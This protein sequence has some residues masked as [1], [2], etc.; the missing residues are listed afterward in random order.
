MGRS[1]HR[2][3]CPWFVHRRVH[4]TKPP[5]IA[6]TYWVGGV[7][8]VRGGRAGRRPGS[9]AAISAGFV[10]L[11]AGRRRMRPAGVRGGANP[12]GPLGC[13]RRA[14]GGSV[15]EGGARHRPS[16]RRRTPRHL[17]R[18]LRWGGTSFWDFCTP[19]AFRRVAWCT[20]SGLL[21]GQGS[22]LSRETPTTAA[23]NA[24]SIP[25]SCEGIP[26]FRRSEAFVILRIRER[27][28][29][30]PE[31]RGAQRAGVSCHGRA[32]VPKRCTRGCPGMPLAY[33]SPEKMH[34]QPRT[35]HARPVR[36]ARKSR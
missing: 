25:P 4:L 32:K 30:K 29:R 22:D 20:F 13:R 8:C 34:R 21:H 7:H 10:R 1:A 26:R 27:L 11:A 9:P 24:D 15:R 19:A 12:A 17:R 23:G 33:R 6:G 36:A 2:P 28:A 18:R 14:A 31:G 35:G 16:A 3:S 5:Q